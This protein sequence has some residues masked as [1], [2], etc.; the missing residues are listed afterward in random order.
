MKTIKTLIAGVTAGMLLFSVSFA[1]ERD[2]DVFS[3]YVE[4]ESF[5]KDVSS[6]LGD[7]WKKWQNTISINGIEVE[8]SC[9]LL[10]PGDLGQPVLNKKMILLDF[11]TVG[12][13]YEYVECVKTVADA[14][15]SSMRKWQRGYSNRGIPFP[16]GASCTFTLPECKNVPV[17]LA[18]GSSSG[19]NVM[20]EEYLYN[21]MMYH[22]SFHS[23]N[24]YSVY[25]A[26]AE[27]IAACFDVWRKNC[28]IVGICASGGIAP[29]VGPMGATPGPVRGAKGNRGKLEGKPICSDIMFETM[30]TYFKDHEK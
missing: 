10:F 17:S 1:S 28:S 26:A 11:D 18:S 27:A 24:I 29:G 22:T 5:A 3:S 16:R 7:S 13:S 23:K 19:D 20:T 21:Y 6:L 4:K 9:G 15:A 14:V 8:G 25:K 30:M 12:R 2:P